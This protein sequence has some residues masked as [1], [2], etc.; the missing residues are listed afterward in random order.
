MD[1][2]FFNSKAIFFEQKTI[3]LIKQPNLEIFICYTKTIANKL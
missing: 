1:G 3:F 2:Y